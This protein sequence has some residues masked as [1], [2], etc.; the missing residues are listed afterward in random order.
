MNDDDKMNDAL[1]HL[2]IEKI[3]C[4]LVLCWNIKFHIN[5]H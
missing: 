5:Y 2:I 3:F 4:K 1:K